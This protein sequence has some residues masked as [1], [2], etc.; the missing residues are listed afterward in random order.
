VPIIA[1][2]AYATRG[3]CEECLEGGMDGYLSKPI[4]GHEMIT[5]VESLA[6]RAL[7]ANHRIEAGLT[8]E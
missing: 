5:L 1:M 4:D 7:R 3:D 2:T 6:A 8:Q